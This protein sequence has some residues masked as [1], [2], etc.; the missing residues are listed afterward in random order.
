MAYT[1]NP[2]MPRLRAKA[3]AMVQSGN[4]IRKVARHFGYQ[5]STVMRWCKRVPLPLGASEIPTASSRPHHHPNEVSQSL[6]NRIIELRKLTDGRCSEVVHQMLLNEGR[7]V[8][9]STV[10]RVL[11][12]TGLTKKKNK[13]R[14]KWKSIPRPKAEREGDLVQ[15]DTIHLAENGHVQLYVYTLLDVFSRWAYAR[16]VVRLS[17]SAS[18]EFIELA[19][20][21]SPFNFHCL[22]SDHGPEFSKIFT[23]RVTIKH[24]HSRVRRPNDNAHL[25]RFNRTI[26]EEFLNKLPV[27]V[28]KIN[29]ELPQYLKYYNEQR[30]HLGLNLKTP[31][32]VLPSY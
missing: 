14:R 10:K 7:K 17:A 21:S 23:Q 27:D 31:S 30:L 5:P 25:E 6:V 16:A 2:Q 11:T 18:L 32:Q 29:Q 26:Q 1:K 15:I 24:R 8:S 19:S 9:L 3:V 13:F 20:H 12:R 22:Q 28:H 4:S